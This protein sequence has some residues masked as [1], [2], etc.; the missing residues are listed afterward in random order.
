[1]PSGRKKKKIWWFVV[2]FA[3]GENFNGYNE[4]FNSGIEDGMA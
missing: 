4:C 3:V 1:M 2:R